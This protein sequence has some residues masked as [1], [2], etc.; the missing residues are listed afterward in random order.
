MAKTTIEYSVNCKR[1]LKP[2]GY[3]GM[4]YE[5]MKEYGQ[6]RPEYCEDC[7]G[8]LLAEKMTMGAAYF[9]VKTIPGVD[10]SVA[11]PGELG[12]VSHPDRPHIKVET[13]QLFDQSKFGATPNKIVEIYE[14][15]KIPGHQVVI[16]IG[17]TGSGK[18]TALPYWLIY[19]P[20]GV[21]SDFFLK[22]GQILITQPRIVATT[23]IS[24]Y[25]G[26]LVGSSVGKGFDIGY[27]YS[28][29]R[30]A[31]RF[32]AAFMATD[33]SLVNMINRGQL[34]DLSV[35]MIDEAHERSLNIDIILRLLRDQLPLYP[36]LK[37]LIVSAT[38]NRE[39]FLN[40]FGTDIATV[41]EFEPK[42]KH[43]Y[44]RYFADEKEK[45]PYDDPGRLRSRLVPALVKKVMWLLEEII[46]GRRER[47]HILTFLH[48]VK[49]IKEAVL[50]IGELIET[51]PKLKNMVDVFPLY[52]DLDDKETKWALEG[53]DNSKIRVIVSTNVAEASVTVEDVAYV[54]ESGVENQAQWNID[55]REKLIELEL[56][57]QANAKQRWGRAGRVR[58]GEVFCLYTEDQFG[59]M[60]EFPIPEI[61]RTSMDDIILTLKKLGV[62]DFE[63]GWIDKPKEE[64]LSRSITSLKDSGAVDDDNMLTEYGLLLSQF[65]YPAPLAD[66]II[67]ADRFGCVVEVASLIPVI[68][69]GGFKNLLL[70]DNNWDQTTKQKVEKIHQALWLGCRDDVEF[71]F[72]LLHF[73]QSPPEM[74][75]GGEGGNKKSLSERRVE[76]C[77]AFY[78]N[79]VT[80]EEDIIPET[81]QVL[82]LLNAHKKDKNFRSIQMSLLFRTKLVLTYCQDCGLTNGD[83]Y[84][85]DGKREPKEG[86]L[87][88]SLLALPTDLV[89]KVNQEKQKKVSSL[90]L[91][92]LMSALEEKSESVTEMVNRVLCEPVLPVDDTV[93]LDAFMEKYHEGDVLTVEVVGYAEH[94]GDNRVSLVVRDPETGYENWI[95]ASD[96][97]FSQSSTL[98]KLIPVGIKLQVKILNMDKE[99]RVVHLERLSIVEEEID[100]VLSSLKKVDGFYQADAQ[101]VEIRKDGKVVLLSNLSVPERGFLLP[102][103]ATEKSL[104]KP[105]VELAANDSLRVVFARETDWENKANLEKVAKGLEEYLKSSSA[106]LRWS[107]GKLSFFGRLKMGE[108]LR[109]RLVDDD[110]LFRKALEYLY[111]ASN[112]IWVRKVI[113]VTKLG[114]LKNRYVLGTQVQGKVSKVIDKGLVIVL[115]DGTKGFV[116]LAEIN[117][118]RRVM[119]A[120][121]VVEEGEV[122]TAKVVG[123][124]DERQQLMLSLIIPENSANRL[125]HSGQVLKGVVDNLTNFGAFVK[126]SYGYSG[127]IHVSKLGQRV[128]MPSEV[129]SKGDQVEV[130]ILSVAERNGKLEISLRLKTII[131]KGS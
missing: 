7:R 62:D 28:K 76:W 14:W 51:N 6:S 86:S 53:R 35:V 37:L 113:D 75:S 63:D 21:P 90:S 16:V 12:K 66:L 31:D 15:L 11:I 56:I 105:V 64:E 30:N 84:S 123:F 81:Q 121:G 85:Y 42:S 40:Y 77:K 117:P 18:S 88:N 50:K 119:S 74:V 97:F 32:N 107:E 120:K 125:F 27:R 5:K 36:H 38:I 54:V 20:E 3:S 118:T 108:Y 59:K 24:E 17:G 60:L 34:A 87:I 19:P 33:G 78:V 9:S 131:A 111:L 94:T 39:S 72:K 10:I 45:L 106:R 79:S 83:N 92:L 1:C 23:H 43:K 25:L 55:K 126:L 93:S 124:D 4:M 13:S 128:K 67:M 96:L 101:V 91:A 41:V 57:S 116:S 73:W 122:I 82:R 103:L 2:I 61:Q 89:E 104:G 115:L 69:N 99:S 109:L 70:W 112:M 71:I 127:L 65:Q 129:L 100:M 110:L 52:S 48:G 68:K 98:V 26:S 22:D 58:D 95:S 44:E 130:E 80:I 47:G 114:E 49:P 29:D 8:E 102:I 46:D